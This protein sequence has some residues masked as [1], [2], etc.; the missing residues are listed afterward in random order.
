[1]ENLETNN[2]TSFFHNQKIGRNHWLTYIATLALVISG[3]IGFGGLPLQIALGLKG[4][5][6]EEIVQM[7]SKEMD[8]YFT[9]NELLIYNIFP[10]IAGFITLIVAAKYIH[11]R[12]PLSYITTRK[13]FDYKRFIVGFTTWATLA[14]GL[15]FL[16]YTLSDHSNL[17]WNF[18][19]INFIFL[20][21]ICLFLVPVQTGFEELLFRGFLLQFTGQRIRKG[22][23]SVLIN[24]LVFGALHSLNP[25]VQV[26]GW[27]ALL[28]YAFSGCFAA[29][30]TV[31]DDG[32]ELAW[33]FHTANNFMG[34]LLVTNN[35]Q[36]FQT[37]ALFLDTSE[38]TMGYEIFISL[39]LWYPLMMVLFSKI[40]R[41]KNWKE[42]LF[43]RG[44]VFT[45]E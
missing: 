5:S 9:L 2:S 30:L 4:L 25:E 6:S 14:I 45:T 27:Q 35:W 38:P 11:H 18:D 40:Y 28:F 19:P 13:Y 7:S 22:I 23:V 43:Y 8:T 26:L 34:I 31:M 17:I 3:I 24:G 33:G 36:V 29:T 10:F 16:Q 37:D 39:F 1:M 21:S 12:S 32:V 41:W 42:R 44:N 15:F 20:L